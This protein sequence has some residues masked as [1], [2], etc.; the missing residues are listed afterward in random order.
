MQKFFYCAETGQVH[1]LE[2]DGSQ[3]QIIQPGWQLKTQAE[4]E[5]LC[6]ERLKPSAEMRRDLLIAELASIDAA[7]ARPLRAIVAGTA[8][9]EDRA[10]LVELEGQAAALRAE[11]EAL[12]APADPVQ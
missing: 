1:A 9:D 11:L 7:S 8:T 2:A 5:A 6:A 4:A 12:R 3:D 10:R